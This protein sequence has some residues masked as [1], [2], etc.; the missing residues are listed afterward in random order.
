VYGKLSRLENEE[1]MERME[2][3]GKWI[4]DVKELRKQVFEVAHVPLED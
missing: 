2:D 3:E 4:F 1:W